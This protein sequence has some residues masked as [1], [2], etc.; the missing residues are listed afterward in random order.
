M[1]DFGVRRAKAAFPVCSTRQQLRLE[2]I[3]SVMEKP[4]MGKRSDGTAILPVERSSTDTL[5][6]RHIFTLPKDAFM[7]IVFGKFSD[8]L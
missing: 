7:L 2:S 3:G 8:Y 6:P 1:S 5:G 4:P